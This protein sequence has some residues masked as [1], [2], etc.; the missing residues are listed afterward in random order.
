MFLV[1]S[2]PLRPQGAEGG[3]AAEYHVLGATGNGEHWAYGSN[4]AFARPGTA[5]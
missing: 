4:V 1:D 2:S 3:A 5:S